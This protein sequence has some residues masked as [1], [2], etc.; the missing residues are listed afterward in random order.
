MLFRSVAT[1]MKEN[2]ARYRP[3]KFGGPGEGEVH[4]G[5]VNH[6]QTSLAF[7]TPEDIAPMVL[8]LASPHASAIMG[9]SI[10]IDG[11]STPGIR[12]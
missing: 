3:A 9:Q 11:G 6:E 2:N 1:G 7:F 5:E 12:Y 4:V 8:F 10:A